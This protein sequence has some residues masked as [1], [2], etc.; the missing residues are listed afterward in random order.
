MNTLEAKNRLAITN[1]LYATDFSSCSEAALPYARDIARLYGSTVLVAHV[2]PPLPIEASF[3]MDPTQVERRERAEL[4]NLARRFKNVDHRTLLLDGDVWPE[5]AGVIKREQ[6]DL[7]VVGTHGRTGIERAALGSVAE[8]IFRQARCPVLT[9][10]PNAMRHPLSHHVQWVD[11]RKPEVESNIKT[12]LYATDFSK[13]SLAAA[14]FALSLAQEHQAKL[15]LLHTVEGASAEYTKDPARIL[16]SLVAE[17]EQ[18]VPEDA[19]LW[20]QP[21]FLV[22]F[23]SPAERIL[24]VSS[25]LKADLIVMGV[26][27]AH[28]H[29]GA[30]THV[31]PATAHKVVSHAQCPVFTVLG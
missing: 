11:G 13:E 12:I 24:E 28:G 18:L 25:E 19:N 26:R 20:C 2:A 16:G 30:A 7:I 23:G 29:I 14:P 27:G 21:E 31:A 10:G 22:D 3:G 1:I 9:V 5:L 4:A 15:V 17:L 6:I 8:E